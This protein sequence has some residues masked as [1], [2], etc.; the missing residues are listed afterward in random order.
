MTAVDHHVPRTPQTTAPPRAALP[1]APPPVRQRDRAIDAV[2]AASLAMVVVLHAMMVGV[3][4]APNGSLVTSVAMSGTDWFIPVSWVIQVMPL[5]FIAGGFSSLGQWRRMQSRGDTWR[6]YL[7]SRTLR[8]A[9]PTA[10]LILLAGLALAVGRLAGLDPALAA[11]ASLRIAQPLWFVAVYLGVTAL[12]PAMSWLHGRAPRHTL[13]VLACAVL[14]VDALRIGL[15]SP[16]IGY[17]NLAFVWL[18]IHQL[19]FLLTGGTL[20]RWSRG[21]FLAGAA[22]AVAVLAL[23][24]ATGLDSA[25]MLAQQNPPTAALVV[26]GT[27][28][29]FLLLWAKPYLE[30]WAARPGPAAWVGAG[31]AHAMTVYLWHMPVILTLVAAMQGMGWPLPEP[32]SPQWWITRVPWLLTIAAG[33]VPAARLLVRIERRG[34][35][36]VGRRARSRRARRSGRI[37]HRYSL[38][39]AASVRRRRTDVHDAK[40]E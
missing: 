33:M 25:D 21:R 37:Q 3:E 11:E 8:L 18:L 13:A 36:W 12:V 17:L 39:C 4:Y 24:I 19:G 16:A 20:A 9:V 10:A 26:F 6:A 40:S 22:T 27:A 7:A 1:S 15:E 30:R 23:M 29:F 5:F 2:R 38:S 28:Q 32:H 34:P 14:T 31:N 35:D